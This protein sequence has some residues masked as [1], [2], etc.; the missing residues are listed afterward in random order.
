MHSHDVIYGVS[1]HV[2]KTTLLSRRI[3]SSDDLDTTFRALFRKRLKPTICHEC[4]LEKVYVVSQVTAV[5]GALI[6]YTVKTVQDSIKKCGIK[7]CNICQP[8][9]LH[10][11][12][13]KTLNMLPDPVPGEDEHYLPFENMYGTPTTEVHAPSSSKRSKKQKTC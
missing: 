12:I 10:Q 1:S 3:I 11:E 13:F 9:R 7:N 5:F 8:S 2:I 6:K 4:E